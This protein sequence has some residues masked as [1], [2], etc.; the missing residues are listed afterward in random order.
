MPKCYQIYFEAI[1]IAS[2]L[3]K[4]N[5]SRIIKNATANARTHA[6][7]H[8]KIRPSTKPKLK[9]VIIPDMIKLINPESKND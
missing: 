5:T 6:R 2:F 1:V 4:G 8:I 3:A 9:K 7:S